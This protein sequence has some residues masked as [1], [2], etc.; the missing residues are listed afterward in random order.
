MHM[1]SIH[2]NLD[3]LGIIHRFAAIT[4]LS[5]KINN[6]DHERSEL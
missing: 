2:V 5:Y 4:I 1:V 3:N 6:R